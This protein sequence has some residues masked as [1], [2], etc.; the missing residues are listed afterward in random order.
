MTESTTEAYLLD[1]LKKGEEEAYYPIYNTALDFGSLLG[2]LFP[3]II[4]LF[5]QFRVIFLVYALG[6]LLLSILSLTIKEVHEYRR[7]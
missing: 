7:R 2:K 6:M 4:L 5:F 3:A 1:I